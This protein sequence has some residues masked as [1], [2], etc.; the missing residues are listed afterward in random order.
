VFL[1]IKISTGRITSKVEANWITLEFI[2]DV[3][4]ETADYLF[5]FLVAA[6][7]Y[8]AV[9]M[10]NKNYHLS[11]WVIFRMDYQSDLFRQAPLLRHYN[12]TPLKKCITHRQTQVIIIH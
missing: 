4:Q 8:N 10:Q 7:H 12:V 2:T 1:Y 9:G 5:G 3:T 6:L 11:I